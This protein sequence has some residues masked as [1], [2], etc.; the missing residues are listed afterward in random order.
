MCAKC[1]AYQNSFMARYGPIMEAM[2][3]GTYDPKEYSGVD[4]EPCEE[5]KRKMQ[6]TQYGR[7]S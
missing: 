5:Y 7:D 6:E 3:N 1:Y 4:E 2:R